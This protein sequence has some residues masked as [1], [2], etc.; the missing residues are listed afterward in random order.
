MTSHYRNFKHFYQK[1]ICIPRKSDFPHL[2]SY[3]R[4][5]E[6]MPS[7]LIPLIYYLNNRKG[8]DTGIS[9]I[10]STRIPICHPKRS[11]SNKVFKGLA[12]W[13]KSSMGWYF[14]FKLHLI[15]NECGELLN[16]QIT[17]GNIDD[18]VPVPM[19]TRKIFGK[20]FGDKGYISKDLWKELWE[21]GLKLITP[22]KKNMRNKLLSLEEKLLLRKRSLIETVTN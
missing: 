14:G 17:A 22:F 11:K 9:F 7:A 1:Y 10:D 15:I 21:S 13:G 2:V 4:F 12:A 19:L 3:Q 20:L 8:C 5:I 18:R 6:L 16:F